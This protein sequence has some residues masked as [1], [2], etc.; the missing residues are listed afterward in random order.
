MWND[1][2]ASYAMKDCLEWPFKYSF[3][4][5]EDNSLSDEYGPDSITKLVEYIQ[6][7][8]VAMNLQIL[9]VLNCCQLYRPVLFIN[10]YTH[11]H[12]YMYRTL[13]TAGTKNAMM[14]AMDLLFHQWQKM[15]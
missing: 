3:F 9:V 5:N 12:I 13:V 14:A 15:L 1:R 10:S 8:L 11:I 6:Q 7:V 2:K 4:L